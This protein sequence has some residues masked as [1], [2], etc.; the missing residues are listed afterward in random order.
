MLQCT[1]LLSPDIQLRAWKFF[2]RTAHFLNKIVIIPVV[3]NMVAK[4]SSIESADL[5]VGHMANG[6]LVRHRQSVCVA[7]NTAQLCIVPLRSQTE[8]KFRP[9]L[10]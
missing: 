5:T 7:S 1:I 8:G 3:Q 6:Y 4:H 9:F 10:L 2:C